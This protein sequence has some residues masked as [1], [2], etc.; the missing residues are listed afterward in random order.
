MQIKNNIFTAS[1]SRNNEVEN[2]RFFQFYEYGITGTSIKPDAGSYS[3][4]QVT[5]KAKLEEV[6]KKI[7]DLV[8]KNKEP[9]LDL[10]IGNLEAK[11]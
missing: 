1:I 6:S 2:V 10:K 9:D 4:I 8:K 3:L 7:Q 11:D 5:D